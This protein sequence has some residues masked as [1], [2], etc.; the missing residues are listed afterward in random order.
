[1]TQRLSA[2]FNDFM[3]KYHPLSLSSFQLDTKV[4]TATIARNRAGAPLDETKRVEG[5]VRDV[6]DQLVAPAYGA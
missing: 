5:I 1:V 3:A 4:V 6:H 2:S